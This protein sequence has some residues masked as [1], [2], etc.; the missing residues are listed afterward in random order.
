MLSCL[1]DVKQTGRIFDDWRFRIL[2]HVI[3]L[4]PVKCGIPFTHF[5]IKTVKPWKIGK[6]KKYKPFIIWSNYQ[7]VEAGI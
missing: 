2:T 5:L 6:Q 3:K 7:S 4:S 1:S